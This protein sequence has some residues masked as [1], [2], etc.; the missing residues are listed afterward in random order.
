MIAGGAHSPAA[1]ES[2]KSSLGASRRKG[3]SLA[4][5]DVFIALGVVASVLVFL[6]FLMRRSVAEKGAHM[7]AE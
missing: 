2:G 1:Q 6:V 5:F 3:S 4:D 7:A